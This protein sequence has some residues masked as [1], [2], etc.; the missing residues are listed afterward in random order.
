MIPHL[1]SC[2]GLAG[3]YTRFALGRLESE[4]PSTFAL[5][6]YHIQLNGVNTHSK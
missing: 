3:I 6:G 1:L 5:L 4:A 2:R